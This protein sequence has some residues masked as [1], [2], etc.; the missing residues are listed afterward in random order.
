MLCYVGEMIAV[1]DLA[2][3]S[4]STSPRCTLLLAV[5]LVF[6]PRGRSIRRRMTALG[7]MLVPRELLPRAIA[8]NSLAGQFAVDLRPGDRRRAGRRRRRRWPSPS[9]FALYLAALVATCPSA[10]GVTRPVTSGGSRLAMVR[11][12]L[13]YVWTNKVVFG[14]ISLDLAR[15]SWAARPRCCRPSRATCC[16]SGPSGFGILRSATAIGAASVALYLARRP[17]RSARRPEACSSASRVFGLGNDRLRPLA[18]AL[19]LGGG[20]GGARRGGHALGV[21]APDAGAAGHARPDARARRRRSPPSSSR[22]PTSSASSAAASWRV[23]SGRSARW[24][25]AAS[26]R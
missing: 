1:V 4:S 20:A 26:A 21:R 7:P 2:R 15:C 10:R 19:A 13:V 9:P 12:G 14:A 24:S 25:S 3:P 8:W 16:M 23:S 17:I 6:G 18:D 22:P 11:E 5:A